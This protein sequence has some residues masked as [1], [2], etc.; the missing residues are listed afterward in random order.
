MAALIWQSYKQI[1]VSSRLGLSQTAVEILNG[2]W[3]G[4]WFNLRSDPLSGKLAGGLPNNSIAAMKAILIPFR[5]AHWVAGKP[6]IYPTIPDDPDARL[7][8]LV[9]NRS[10]R[11]DALIERHSGAVQ[12]FVVLGAGWDVRGYS[13]HDLAWFEV[14]R[15]NEQS[16]KRA[17]L[18]RAGIGTGDIVYVSADFAQKDWDQQLC[19]NGFDP[20][21]KTIFLWEGVTLYLSEDEVRETLDKIRQIAAS[22]S[23]LLL[24]FYA[25][26]FVE[27]AQRGAM[28]WSLDLTGEALRFG[29]DLQKEGASVIEAIAEERGF[30]LGECH[31]LGNATKTGAYAAVA[32]FRV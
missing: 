16:F 9:L 21:V 3:S 32:E 23:V 27:K 22:G 14:D 25:L 10:R 13:D 17:A 4:E 8:N 24:D 1:M 19:E 11:F 31:L 30:A 29:L 20:S 15:D 7:A 28:A 26:G 12:Q 6:V 18:Q 5:I 2:R